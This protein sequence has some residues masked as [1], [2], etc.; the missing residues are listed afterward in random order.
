MR[1]SPLSFMPAPLLVGLTPV[2]SACA[3]SGSPQDSYLARMEK[4]STDCEARGGMLA[5]SGVQ[6]GRPETDNVCKIFG[7]GSR[8]PP[9][10]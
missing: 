3:S 10:N 9:Q 4:L 1:R 8:L 6:T 7:G 2:L 5:P